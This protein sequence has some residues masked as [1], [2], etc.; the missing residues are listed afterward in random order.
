M[1]RLIARQKILLSVAATCVYFAAAQWSESHFVPDDG[2][3][4]EAGIRVRLRGPFKAVS[5]FAAS[6]LPTS[7]IFD[8]PMYD[9]SIEL[10]EGN[11]KLG[12]SQ[13]MPDDIASLGHGRFLHRAE[14]PSDAVVVFSSSDNTDPVTNGRIYWIVN[15][16]HK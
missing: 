14:R 11:K 7:G 6:T 5:A 15:S 8:Q 3:P 16:V 10:W 13:S 1:F 12:P 2:P 9:A 4:P